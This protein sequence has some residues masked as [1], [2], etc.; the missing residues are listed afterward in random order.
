MGERYKAKYFKNQNE[1]S[2][3]IFHATK[4]TRE[5]E[6]LKET[7]KIEKRRRR[8]RKTRRRKQKF[9][10]PLVLLHFFLH[11]IFIHCAGLLLLR[12]LRLRLPLLALGFLFLHTY[13]GLYMCN[14]HTYIRIYVLISHIHARTRTF[15]DVSS[16][17]ACSLV[18]SLFLL[19]A[20]LFIAT[21]VPFSF[22]FSPIVFCILYSRYLRIFFFLILVYFSCVWYFSTN[23]NT[24]LS[25]SSCLRPFAS[26]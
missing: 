20:V 6:K 16:V 11:F 1:N 15:F 21:R 24:F 12:L 22:R 13:T 8:H 4:L 25:L 2:V 19:P 10:F 5:Q 9:H 18:R 23:I 7:E 17:F 3:N 14:I 26:L